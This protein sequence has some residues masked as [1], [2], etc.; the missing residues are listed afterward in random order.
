MR[1]RLSRKNSGKSKKSRKFSKNATIVSSNDHTFLSAD[2]A[3]L[4]FV[5]AKETEEQILEYQE[6]KLISSAVKVEYVEEVKEE[7]KPQPEPQHQVE[8]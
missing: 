3:R 7:V 6:Q 4:S 8:H 5:T 2:G 1:R